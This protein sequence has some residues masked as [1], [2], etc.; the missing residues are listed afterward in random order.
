MV[1]DA[2]NQEYPNSFPRERLKPVSTIEE[3]KEPQYSFEKILDDRVINGRREYLI[4]WK[5]GFEPNTWEP[6]ENIVDPDFINEYHRNKSKSTTEEKTTTIRK[7]GRPAKVKINYALLLAI[8][9]SLILNTASQRIREEFFYCEEV[10]KITEDTRVF[11]LFDK[12][13]NNRNDLGKAEFTNFALAA[14][15]SE[16]V[17]PKYN[18]GDR[19]RVYK[20][21]D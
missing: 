2:L 9:F 19:D 4:Q 17:S 14:N 5:S 11:D 21:K 10:E 18:N 12:C 7:R 13:D 3:E 16:G 8:I 1:K 20:T 15:I 6:A